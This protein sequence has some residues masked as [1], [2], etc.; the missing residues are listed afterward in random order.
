MQRMFSFNK[1]H[2]IASALVIALSFYSCNKEK[3]G[4][5]AVSPLADS[6]SSTIFISNDKMHELVVI[7]NPGSVDGKIT[8]HDAKENKE[9][10]LQRVDSGS[11]IKYESENGYSLWT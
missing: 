7:A 2:F 3:S 10:E 4:H 9:Y 1:Y 6:S 8:V 5:V 11:G